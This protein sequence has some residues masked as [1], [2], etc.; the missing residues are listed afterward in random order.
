MSLTLKPAAPRRLKHGFGPGIFTFTG[1]CRLL[2]LTFMTGPWLLLTSR[3]TAKSASLMILL[4]APALLFCAMLTIPGLIFQMPEQNAYYEFSRILN[5][6]PTR[7]YVLALTGVF[8][9]IAL[10]VPASAPNPFQAI[11][12]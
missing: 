1:A 6:D 5:Q 10:A 2:R 11:R 12:H 8:A 9:L 4:C 3:L 7:W